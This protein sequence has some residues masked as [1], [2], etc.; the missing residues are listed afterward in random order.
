MREKRQSLDITA[1]RIASEGLLQQLVSLGVFTAARRI[2]MYMA[3]GGEIDPSPVMRWC[4]GRGIEVYV[5]I[6][7]DPPD[8]MLAFAS[9]TLSTRFAANRYLIDEPEVPSDKHIPPRA[10]DVVLM[11]L[12]AFDELGNRIGMGG[13]F[14][15][16]SFGFVNDEQVKLPALIGIAHDFQKVDSIP[17]ESWDV[18]LRW[19]VTP[20]GVYN[21]NYTVT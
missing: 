19:V 13:G 5:P 3:S 8:R 21:G 18:P 1:Q 4:W 10:L 6:V 11:P 9:V 15:D 14:Y 16:V 2:G 17:F 20:E 12:V 7:P